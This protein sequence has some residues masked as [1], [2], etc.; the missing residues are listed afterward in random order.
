M[1][2]RVRAVVSLPAPTIA[3]ASPRQSFESLLFGWQRAVPHLVEYCVS[4]EL[5]FLLWCLCHDPSDFHIHLF[6]EVQIAFERA[7][8]PHDYCWWKGGD[9]P[10]DPREVFKGQEA[11]KCRRHAG[12]P[13]LV[14]VWTV[15]EPETLTKGIGCYDVCGHSAE[16]GV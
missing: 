6:G 10:P 5:V 11:N 9:H 2:N 7:V 15:E 8:E 4:F 3:N 12:F 16:S 13:R 1:R 14:E